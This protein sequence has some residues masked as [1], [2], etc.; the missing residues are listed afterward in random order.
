[1][2]TRCRLG[3]PSRLRSKLQY[4][5]FGTDGTS[6]HR[7]LSLCLA[8]TASKHLVL[9]SLLERMAELPEGFTYV[10]THSGW[11]L[12]DLSAP[13]A[14]VHQNHLYGIMALPD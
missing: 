14:S 2:I 1:M 5:F 6:E 10:D 8:R 7:C 9:A 12:Y 4:L 13:Q 11:G 3:A